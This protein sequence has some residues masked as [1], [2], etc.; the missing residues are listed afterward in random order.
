MFVVN[1]LG[2]CHFPEQ[3]VQPVLREPQFIAVGLCFLGEMAD[4]RRDIDGPLS[5]L[6]PMRGDLVVCLETFLLLLLMECS[7]GSFTRKNI[8]QLRI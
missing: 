2:K 1:G 6:K 5:D 7:I 8:S 4:H 3:P